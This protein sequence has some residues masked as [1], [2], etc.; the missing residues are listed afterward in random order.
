[1]G[2]GLWRGGNG[3]LVA[4]RRW[5]VWFVRGVRC[6]MFSVVLCSVLKYVVFVLVVCLF[7]P[8]RDA[9]CAWNWQTMETGKFL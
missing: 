1:V 4:F 5:I 2:V 8:Y 6:E 9:F 3:L 7:S